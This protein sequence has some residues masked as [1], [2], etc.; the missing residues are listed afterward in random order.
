[1]T[2]IGL[3]LLTCA[4]ICAWTGLWMFA[5]LFALV[6]TSMFFRIS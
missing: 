1:M 4:L 3:I 5:I 2:L 6:G